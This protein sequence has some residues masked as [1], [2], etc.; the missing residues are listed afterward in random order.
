MKEGI[1]SQ[2]W[3]CREF[4]GG[5]GD[6]HI[7]NTLKLLRI[8]ILKKTNGKQA[9]SLVPHWTVTYSAP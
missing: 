6:E 9:G 7:Y 4:R 8:K 3:I 1:G 5:T 2:E